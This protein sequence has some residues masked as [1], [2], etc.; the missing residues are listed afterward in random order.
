[1]LSL[2]RTPGQYIVIGDSI[3]VQVVDING[4]LRLAIDAPKE[5]S[6]QRGE[7]YEQNHD[8]PKSVKNR[9]GRINR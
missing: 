1:M 2:G 5:I 9:K 4:E 7:V 6:I 8:T 3:V